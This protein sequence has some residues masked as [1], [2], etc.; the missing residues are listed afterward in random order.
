VST[1]TFRRSISLLHSVGSRVH[2]DESKAAAES[3]SRSDRAGVNGSEYRSF[4]ATTR[5]R[6][7][8]RE[9]RYHAPVQLPEWL[10]RFLLS[11]SYHCHLS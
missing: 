6:L 2:A 11:Q 1:V 4:V 3:V 7:S 10:A 9:Y 8:F 5:I